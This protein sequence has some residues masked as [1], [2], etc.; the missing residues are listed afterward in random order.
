MHCSIEVGGRSFIIGGYKCSKISEYKNGKFAELENHLCECAVCQ[1]DKENILIAGGRND[2]NMFKTCILFN[3]NTL[4]FNSISNMSQK[5]LNFALVECNQKMYAIGG[6]DGYK[7]LH[8]IESYNKTTKTSWIW[9]RK[10]RREVDMKF[11]RSS[12]QATSYQDSIFIFGGS[13]GNDRY[14]NTIDVYHTGTKQITEIKNKLL[15]GRNTFAL[16]QN[17]NQVYLIGGFTKDGRTNKVELFDLKTKTSRFIE[18]LPY[19][20]SSLSACILFE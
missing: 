17:N 13:R 2:S 18:N 12:H 4:Q 3:I 5:R 14:S 19:S 9:N 8:S 10:W 7:G 1:Y 15:I 6:F 16:C 20:D 11:D